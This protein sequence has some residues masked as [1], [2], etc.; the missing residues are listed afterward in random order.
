MGRDERADRYHVPGARHG[1]RRAVPP[2][3]GR[4]QPVCKAIAGWLFAWHARLRVRGRQHVPARGPVIIAA[5]HRSMLD[6]PL[7]VIASPRPVFLM[8]KADIYA[9][10]VLG[11][12]FH[13]LGGF[14]VRREIADVRALD[15][16]LALLER[17]EV[18]GI[19]PEGTRSKSGDMLPFL[20]GAAWLALRTGAPIVPCGLVGTAGTYADRDR[21][22]LSRWKRWW[23]DFAPRRVTITFGPPIEAGKETRAAVRRGRM[24]ELTERLLAEI[25]ALAR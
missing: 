13:E 25:A 2:G 1:A 23:S 8:A 9:N 20:G 5:N 12:L 22:T 10:H 18:V 19:Y 6:I 21:A 11:R 7:L 15:T 14:P 16:A 24:P 3:L 17:G 4:L